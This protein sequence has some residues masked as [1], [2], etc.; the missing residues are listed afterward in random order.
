ML[1][2]SLWVL[3]YTCLCMFND[4]F[5]GNTSLSDTAHSMGWWPRFLE[6]TYKENSIWFIGKMETAPTYKIA[7]QNRTRESH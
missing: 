4:V 6:K 7:R 5:V 2:D 1:K 3:P